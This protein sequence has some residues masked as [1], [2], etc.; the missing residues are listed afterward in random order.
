[1]SWQTAN[2]IPGVNYTAFKTAAGVHIPTGGR[3]VAYVRSGGVQAQ[4][5]LD[6]KTKIVTDLNTALGRCR[7]SYGDVV[8]VMNGHTENIDSADDM[9]NLVAD[10]KIIG[11]G[12]GNERPTFTWSTA[13]STF[14]FD[15]DGVV[16]SNCILNLEPG[17]G[18]VTVAAPITVSG[19]GCEISDCLMRFSTDADNK[20][21]QAFT[22]TGDDFHF[23]GNHCYGATAGE[24]T[25]FMDVNAAHRLVMIGNYI[26]GATAATTNGLLRFVTAASLNIY[27]KGNVY[28]NRK[29]L[30]DSCVTGLAAV[31]GI[32]IDEHFAYLDTAS[33]TAWKTST[34]IMHFHRP[35]VTNTAGET[36]SETVGTVSA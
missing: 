6:V 9:D 12:T 23:N 1:M 2:E 26:A 17:T 10:T 11:L 25:A 32:S 7:A 30:S 24:C 4:D 35:T 27:L 34:G 8:V 19:N 28:I 20:V 14:L 29:A 36:G 18:T 16:L 22:V 33:L 5:P 13:T 3:I 31:S 21:T 15:Q